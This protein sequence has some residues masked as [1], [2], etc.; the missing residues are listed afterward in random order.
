MHLALEELIQF[1]G[2]V[3][4]LL[5]CWAEIHS[6]GRQIKARADTGWGNKVLR[7]R[8]DRRGQGGKWRLGKLLYLSLAWL[9]AEVSV[10]LLREKAGA[11]KTDRQMFFIIP[12]D[13][14][15]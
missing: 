15:V 12:F 6:Q 13:P 1:V 2:L 10:T 11:E 4:L 8:E 7:R 5:R 9:T 14:A 3:L